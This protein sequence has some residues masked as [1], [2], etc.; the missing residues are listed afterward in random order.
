MVSPQEE[1]AQ[2]LFDIKKQLKELEKRIS[3]MNEEKL[4]KKK[5]KEVI[6]AYLCN[7]VCRKDDKIRKLR[8]GI[9]HELGLDLE[10]E[11]VK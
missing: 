8:D 11:N 1:L 4:D 2:I 5:V 7:Y 3:Q 6:T 10:K 9:L